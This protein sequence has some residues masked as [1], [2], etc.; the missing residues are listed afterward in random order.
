[1]RRSTEETRKRQ[2]LT[3]VI[4][5]ILS[6]L[7]AVFICMLIFS[8]VAANVDVSEGAFAVMSGAALSA[9]CFS[10]AY[11][12]AKR[13]R[14]NGFLTGIACGGIVFVV[15]LLLGAIFVRS[16]SAGGFFVKLLIVLSCSGIGGIIGV[17]S[18]RR[19]R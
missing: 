3:T 18:P 8:A 5:A 2:T 15:V 14:R 19:F 12:V 1:M 16:F 17:N 9:G 7:G 13:R 11:S 10:A 4:T 6:C